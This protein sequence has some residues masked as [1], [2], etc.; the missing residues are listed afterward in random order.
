MEIWQ[1]HQKKRKKRVTGK[2]E[3]MNIDTETHTSAPS[4]VP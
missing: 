1:N 2:A 3:E 4:G